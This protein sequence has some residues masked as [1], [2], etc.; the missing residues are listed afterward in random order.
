MI[1]RLTVSTLFLLAIGATSP[2][3]EMPEFPKPT[4]E[5]KWLEQFV[6][7]WESTA[8]SEAVPGVPEMTCE[9]KISSRMLG[10]FFVV[11]EM[12]NNV[13]GMEIEA[14]QT[15][16]YDP[17]KKKYIGTYTDSMMSHMW[18]YEGKVDE[19]GKIL[20]LEAEGPNMMEP[21]KT[22]MY[23]DIYEFKSK[24]EIVATAQYQD[25]EGKW[26]TMMKG[27]SKRVKK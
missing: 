10:G 11:N 3:Q 9:G 26:V 24:D 2:A 22:A 7:E 6:G 8:K 1:K 20:T 12:K 27:T 25:A 23:R 5:H 18:V 19:T 21:G 16:G 14:I 15:I 13:E 17:Q 4:E